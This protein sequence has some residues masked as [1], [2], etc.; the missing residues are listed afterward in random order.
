MTGFYHFFMKE[1]RNFIFIHIPLQMSP[2]KNIDYKVLTLFYIDT[3]FTPY[4][5]L[6]LEFSAISQTVAH[7]SLKD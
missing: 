1:A 3:D 4:A 7:F 6:S 2:H 5:I